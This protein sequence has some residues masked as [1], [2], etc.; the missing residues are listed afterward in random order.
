MA[1]STHIQ[2]VQTVA[3]QSQDARLA[4]GEPIL[5]DRTLGYSDHHERGSSTLGGYCRRT[6]RSRCHIRAWHDR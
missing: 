5:L 1:G 4:L 2:D 3:R 6:R